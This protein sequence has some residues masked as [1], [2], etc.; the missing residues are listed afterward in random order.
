MFKA[1]FLHK[2]TASMSVNEVRG[3]KGSPEPGQNQ[4]EA[5]IRARRALNLR[6]ADIKATLAAAGSSVTLPDVA[7][8][9]LAVQNSL[10]DAAPEMRQAIIHRALMLKGSQRIINET[11]THP[12]RRYIALAV[13]RGL[14][15]DKSKF[16]D[17][18]AD[19]EKAG[20]KGREP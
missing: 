13:I 17:K 4:L 9:V 14:L 6:T 18:R 8:A 3:R 2:K 20:P 1:L 15:D 16:A 5:R 7:G 12:L 10:K 11:L 19:A